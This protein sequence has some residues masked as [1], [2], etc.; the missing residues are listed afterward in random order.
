MKIYFDNIAFSIQKAGG[1][2]AVWAGLLKNIPSKSVVKYFE[3]ENQ[4][5][6]RGKII[7]DIEKIK[8]MPNRLFTIRRF[9]KLKINDDEKFIFHSS[10]YRTSSNK[11]A[12]N[13]ITIH[14]FTDQLYPK[15]IIRRNLKYL[16]MKN[17]IMNSKAIICISENTKKDLIKYFP[18]IDT[19]MVYVI[20]NGKSEDFKKI[21]QK[22]DS[23]NSYVIFVGKRS[24]YKNFETLVKAMVLYQHK[25]LL[26]V[27]G[28]DLSR[29][30][31]RLLSL[32]GY[33][34]FVHY[35][36]ISDKKLNELY[37]NAFC[38]VYPS[39]YEGFGIP[40]IEAQSA[41]CPVIASNTS[42]LPEILGETA[43]LLDEVT[44][45]N[46]LIALRYLED[47]NN[48]NKLV[49]LGIKN[50]ARFTWKKMSDQYYKVYQDLW[51]R[52]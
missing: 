35:K 22:P 1:V 42:S 39:L 18:N 51:T 41:G 19:Q 47:E 2:T 32:L 13:V 36:R 37:N 34:K 16:R 25:K 49:N 33:D 44:P 40:V 15:S 26:V 38:L 12:I 9:L 52:Y 7:L 6:F 31:E 23:E 45:S 27:G 10:V 4:N 30:E 28:G 14:D 46:I 24:G 8:K 5:I 48:R 17:S 11:K 29:K 50:A 20:H 21:G 3:W 43:I